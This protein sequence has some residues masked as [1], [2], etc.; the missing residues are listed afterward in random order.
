MS[1]LS[2]DEAKRINTN[3]TPRRIA[4]SEAQPADGKQLPTIAADATQ[5]LQWPLQRN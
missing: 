1:K 4:S 3:K 5:G 2:G